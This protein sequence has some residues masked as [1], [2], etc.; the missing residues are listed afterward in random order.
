MCDRLRPGRV[1][2][3]TKATWCA[4]ASSLV[5]HSRAVRRS[6]PDPTSFAKPEGVAQPKA[7]IGRVAP[8]GDHP[9]AV[10]ARIHHSRAWPAPSCTVDA[11][12]NP[13]TRSA[14]PEK[15]PGRSEQR[16]TPGWEDPT[17]RPCRIRFHA[18]TRA[19]YTPDSTYVLCGRTR[20]GVSPAARKP[21]SRCSGREHR[22]GPVE[23]R[24]RRE[25]NSTTCW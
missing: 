24:Q 14:I 2:C 11:R 3:V 7:W 10:T 19:V 16:R 1:R 25:G 20:T 4:G 9:R 23:L 6:N 12:G 17:G 21:P 22:D 13:T 15:R 8:D 5:I 18:V